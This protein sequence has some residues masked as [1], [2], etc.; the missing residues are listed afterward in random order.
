MSAMRSSIAFLAACGTVAL[1]AACG[2]RGSTDNDAGHATD[3]SMTDLGA[4]DSGAPDAASTDAGADTGAAVDL[5]SADL[6]GV[7][8][9]EPCG[10][11]YCTGRT[12][13]CSAT[14]SLCLS[15]SLVC[16]ADPCA[17]HDAGMPP[18]LPDGGI[19]DAGPRPDGGCT[20]ICP[21]GL[22]CMI[23][24]GTPTCLSPGATC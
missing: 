14:C 12:Y 22:T 4:T 8:L 5:G 1:L 21:S 24:F 11:N 6:T 7:D 23:C 20:I 10:F 16:G 15:D 13:C 17:G 19:R 3:M 9:G 2:G 18:P